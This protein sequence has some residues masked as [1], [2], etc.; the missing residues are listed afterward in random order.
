MSATQT[1][2]KDV[3]GSATLGR[4]DARKRRSGQGDLQQST[5]SCRT[6]T[7]R[8]VGYVRVSTGEQAENGAGLDAQRRAI[9]VAMEGRGFELV[10]MIEDA[11]VSGKNLA[12][13]G[14]ERALALIESGSA[15][16]LVVAKLDRLS[17]SLLDFAALT[18]RSRRK[19]WALI[20][21]DL[22]V[23]TS[24]PQGE[25]L[26]NVLA[27]FAQFERRL[28]GQR[29]KDALAVKR[30]QGVRLGRPPTVP[31]KLRTRIKG[32][33]TRGWTLQRIANT[34]DAEKIPTAQGG[35]RWYPSTVAAVLN[36]DRR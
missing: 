18:E 11:G 30:A 28:I 31:A 9:A 15:E 26:A 2:P 16:G 24:T 19:G 8:M 1:P 27:T 25:M 29:T 34:L 6:E 14:L 7:V 3:R 32:M 12:R 10:D 22:G 5:D 4:Q 21:L 33:R 36:G 13:P 17:R 35:K 23:D 20:A